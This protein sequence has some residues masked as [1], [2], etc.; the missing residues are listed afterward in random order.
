MAELKTK[1][2]NA[3]VEDF[4][5]SIEDKGMQSDSFQLVKIFA[6]I[7]NEPAKMWGSSIIGFGK[8]SYKSGSS[9]KENDMPLAAF[10][11]RK[12][13]ITLYVMPSWGIF[14]DL[15]AKLGTYTTS[16]ACLYI[17]KLSDVDTE[18]LKDVI[19]LSYEES[20]RRLL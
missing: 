20:K 12:Q 1:V 9:K 2:N 7:T 4:I 3:S 18:V 14:D 16:K 6:A 19:E 5:S 10:S 8:Y 15:F 17:K 11:P 13:Y